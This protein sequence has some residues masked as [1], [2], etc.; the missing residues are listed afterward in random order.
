MQMKGSQKTVDEATS[1]SKQSK[2]NSD[3]PT[4]NVEED[5]EV[6]ENND[7]GKKGSWVWKHF[8]K[9]K[10]D[11][12][13]N[14]VKCPYCPKLMCAH[15]KKNGTI[16]MGRQLRLYCVYS[17]VYDPKGKSGDSKKKTNIC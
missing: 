17:P 12:T 9:N 8:D 14:K 11:K 4:V 5:E 13:L 3:P 7:G 6:S 1:R 10:I 16:S 2:S 15:T